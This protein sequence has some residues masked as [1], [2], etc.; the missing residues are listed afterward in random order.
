MKK[1]VITIILFPL[2]AGAG[3]QQTTTTLLPLTQTAQFQ[4]QGID[5]ALLFPKTWEDLRTDQPEGGMRFEL[6]EHASFIHIQTLPYSTT[7]AE[8]NPNTSGALRGYVSVSY[9]ND[10][11]KTLDTWYGE[12]RRE[13]TEMFGKPKREN[14][15]KIKALDAK[16]IMFEQNDPYGQITN[17][18]IKNS[19]RFVYIHSGTKI[20]EVKIEA[21]KELYDHFLPTFNAIVDSVQIVN[22]RE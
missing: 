15:Q 2:L 22:E 19:Y 12:H 11:G 14:T 20:F 4:Q 5:V 21:R 18:V 16:S 3:C 13:L 8:L 7:F 6:Q 1:G 10:T 17:T 9:F